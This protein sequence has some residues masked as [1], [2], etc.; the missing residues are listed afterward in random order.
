MMMSIATPDA[1][2]VGMD[3]DLIILSLPEIAGLAV[4]A[5]RGAGYTWGMAEES[6]FAAVWLAKYGFDWANAL[7]GR[8]SGDRNVTVVPSEGIW[9]SDRPVCAMH[10]GAALADF[11]K[12]PEGPLGGGVVLGDLYG[13]LCLL[14]FAARAAQINGVALD[15]LVDAALWARVDKSSVR[16]AEPRLNT[17]RAAMITVRPAATVNLTL[18]PNDCQRT[19]AISKLTYA[20]LDALA[21]QMTV[22]ATAQSR[23]GAGAT[24]SDND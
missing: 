11:A 9:R 4:R 14:P 20:Q 7:L 22:P 3:A 10:A 24:G 17:L 18:A 23:A 16:V 8:L 2:P 15:V 1:Q 5:A 6:G 12:L 21:L 19:A 13:P